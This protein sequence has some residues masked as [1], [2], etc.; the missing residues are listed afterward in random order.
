MME[1]NAVRVPFD[2]SYARLPEHFFARVTPAQPPA[3]ALV[4]LNRPLAA[5]LGLNADWLAGPEGLDILSGRRAADGSEPIAL[6]YAGH[7]F[8]NFVPRLGDGR[9]ILIGEVTDLQGRRRDIHLKGTGRTP[10]SRGGDGRAVLGPVLRE[11]LVS[12]AMAALGIPT[13]RAL[14]AVTTGEPVLRETILPGAILARV[15]SSHIRVGTF[16]FFAARDDN[17]AVRVLADHVIGRH[18]PDVAT[19]EKPYRAMLERIIAA[20]AELVAHWMLVGFI[21]GVMN[22]DNTSVAGETIDYGPCAFKDAFHPATV[23][24]SIDRLSRY[25]Y[26]NQPRAAYWNLV[27][28][29]ECLLPLLS[30]KQDEAIEIAQD[31]LEVFVPLFDATYRRGLRRKLGLHGEQ[32]GDIGLADAILTAMADNQVDFTL[33]FRRLADAAPGRDEAVRSLFVDPTAFDAWAVGWRTRLADDPRTPETRSA[34]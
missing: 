17:E 24:S 21:H 7:Q 6:A 32:D 5:E 19:T 34:T 1:D 22:I 26:G 20:Q 25:A 28:L 4:R 15:A 9:A 8:G 2:N 13:T 31:T 30:D 12:E 10:F 33:F 3:P 27:R 29:A 11:Y 14:A 23:F 16:Q 18:Y